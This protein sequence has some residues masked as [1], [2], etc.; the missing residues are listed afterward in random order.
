M[1]H[2]T[3]RQ[4]QLA[5]RPVSRNGL[6][7]NQIYQQ[8]SPGVAF[9]QAASAPR[10]PSPLNPFGGGGGGAATGPGFLL[11]HARHTLPHTHVVDRASKDQRTPGNTHISSP[12]TGHV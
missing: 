12:G 8:D 2:P 6:T 1:N 4:P 11:H 3:T 9:I 7:V 5:P 10:A